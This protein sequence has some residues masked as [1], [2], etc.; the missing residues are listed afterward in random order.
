[1]ARHSANENPAVELVTKAQRRRKTLVEKLWIVE[2]S[3][4]PGISV[5]L[6]DR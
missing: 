4:P 5:S 1:M 3:S 6:V 2:E